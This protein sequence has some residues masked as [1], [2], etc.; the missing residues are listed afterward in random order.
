MASQTKTEE[1][2][3]RALVLIFE[4]EGPD[5]VRAYAQRE[6]LGFAY[7]EEVLRKE[8]GG[9]ARQKRDRER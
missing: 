9:R 3:H 2:H 5:G 4:V 8:L 6:G 1:E 7:C